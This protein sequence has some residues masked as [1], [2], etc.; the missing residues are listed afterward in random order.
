MALQPHPFEVAIKGGEIR[1][2][3]KRSAPR[4]RPVARYPLA[5]ARLVPAH[6]GIAKQRDQVVSDGP[7]DRILEI[8]NA[9][10]GIA[11][12]EIARHVI[13]MHV[14]LR[15]RQRASRERREERLHR[16]ARERVRRHIEVTPEIPLREERQLTLEENVVIRRQTIR[17]A[18]ALQRNQ[19][20]DGIGEQ[21]IGIVVVER[22]EVRCRAEV[23]QQEETALHILRQHLGHV[24]SRLAHQL[25]DANERPTVL[26]FRRRVHHDPAAGAVARA[27]LGHP[28]VAAKA[29]VGG[30]RGEGDG[31]A[32][33]DA[34]L[35]ERGIV[36]RR[37]Q[38]MGDRMADDR[39]PVHRLRPAGSAISSRSELRPA[40]RGRSCT[41]RRRRGTCR[42]R[43]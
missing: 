1:R 5:H 43:R 22:L 8:E 13:A 36:H 3:R 37:R 10:I 27:S 41:C 12:H 42:S 33:G 26:A 38:R 15:L 40:P 9:R 23:G 7:E 4:S 32:V 34:E 17:A 16:F 24:E 25:G 6:E 20:R 30:G 19:R 28:K 11:E 14:D 18:R 31:G 39:E 35:R 29:G 2:D 21:A